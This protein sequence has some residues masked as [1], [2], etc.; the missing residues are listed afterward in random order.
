MIV[1]MT[2][3][4][5]DAT[6]FE[7]AYEGEDVDWDVA[8]K[9]FDAAVDCPTFGFYKVLMKKYPDAKIVHTT[10]DPETWYESAKNTIYHF[11]QNVPTDVPEHVRVASQM[12]R[13]NVWAGD[14]Q[15]KFADKEA[16]IRLFNEHE[17][18]VRRSVPADRL[19]IFETGVD[20]WEKLCPF[21][22][23]DIPDKPWP[24]INTTKEF[25]TA[26]GN[27]TKG[28]TLPAQFTIQTS[29]AD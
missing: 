29:V 11:E 1:L 9:G 7:R 3:P 8:Y 5:N 21:L 10:R 22:G 15:G 2:D 24:H 17:E 18:D 4:K 25:Q 27:I 6:V 13:K 12:V 26:T 16:M 14:F 19:L 20:G 23:K 28:E